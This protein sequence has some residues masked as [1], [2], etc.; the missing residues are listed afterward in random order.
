MYPH[1][2]APLHMVTYA[3][4]RNWEFW[5]CVNYVLHHLGGIWILIIQYTTVIIYWLD[6]TGPDVAMVCI[7]ILIE[8]I[9]EWY[10]RQF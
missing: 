5:V 9:L 6:T 10:K 8:D 7:N 1:P 3:S 4:N 2:M